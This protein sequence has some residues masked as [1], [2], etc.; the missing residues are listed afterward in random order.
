MSVKERLRSYIKFKG[1]KI[2]SFEKSIGASNAYVNNIRQSIAPDKLEQI[3]NIYPDL[4]IEWLLTG[5]GEMISMKGKELDDNYQ[6]PKQEHKQNN[7]GKEIF[8][9]YAKTI[10]HIPA[11]SQLGLQGVYYAEDF[12]RELEQGI[13]YTEDNWLGQYFDIECIGD[14]MDSGDPRNAILEGDHLK[15]REIPR[16]LW[17]NKLHFNEWDEFTFFHYKKGIIT[18]H[19][20]DHKPET[21]DVLIHSYNPN[22]IEF[23]DEWINLSDVAKLGNVV[24]VNKPRGFK[25]RLNKL[26]GK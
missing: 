2:S 4:N 22:K 3:A 24:E 16:H 21:G 1:F 18:K 7:E 26:N 5:N 20:L 23:P 13:I 6:V 11:K 19:V 25:K 15:V 9:K 14:S 10:T 12:M 8:K 17:K